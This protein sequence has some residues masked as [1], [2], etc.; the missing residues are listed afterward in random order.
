L[1]KGA[2]SGLGGA[3]TA[4]PGEHLEEAFRRLLSEFGANRDSVTIEAR[5]QEIKPSTAPDGLLQPPNP[6][7][8]DRNAHGS[9]TS[10]APP[11]PTSKKTGAQLTASQARSKSE[12]AK[13]KGRKATVD[14]RDRHVDLEDR[15]LSELLNELNQIQLRPQR[16][17]G[18]S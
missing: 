16:G 1:E 8:A 13:I 18:N 15:F 2:G 14:S 3:A 4:L 10:P 12:V 11:D 6:T 5:A 17:P 9:P 7:S